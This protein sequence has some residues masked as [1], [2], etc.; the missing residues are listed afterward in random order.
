MKLQMNYAT[1]RWRTIPSWLALSW[2]PWLRLS[3][4]SD[5]RTHRVRFEDLS[6]H[7]LRDL[8]ISARDARDMMATERSR[9]P[10]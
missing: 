3:R 2:F 6:P 7:V 8:G 10:S 5:G 9:L 4:R 1:S